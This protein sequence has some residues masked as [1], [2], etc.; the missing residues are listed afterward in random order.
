[1][2]R[3]RERVRRK[4]YGKPEGKA[5]KSPQEVDNTNVNSEVNPRLLRMFPPE[6]IKRIME[7][8]ARRYKASLEKKWSNWFSSVSK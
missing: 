7:K 8:E 3:E 5:Q 6:R 2:N 1:M 4:I